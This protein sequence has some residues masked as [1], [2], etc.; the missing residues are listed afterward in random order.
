MARNLVPAAIKKTVG[1]WFDQMGSG[2]PATYSSPSGQ[3]PTPAE[4]WGNWPNMFQADLPRIEV[5]ED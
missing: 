4:W 1:H 3:S 5:D 2:F